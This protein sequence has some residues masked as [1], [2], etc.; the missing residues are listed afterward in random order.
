[1]VSPELCERC[2]EVGVRKE[3]SEMAIIPIA[4]EAQFETLKE[5]I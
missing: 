3:R 1:M 2:A 5:K 4:V